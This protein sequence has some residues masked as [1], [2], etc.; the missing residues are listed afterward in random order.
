MTETTQGMVAVESEDVERIYTGEEVE[1]T[2]HEPGD[3]RGDVERSDVFVKCVGGLPDRDTDVEV[4]FG[5][6]IGITTAGVALMTMTN[7]PYA[8]ELL[9]AGVVTVV[10]ATVVPRITGGN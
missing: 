7:S 1:A 10:I 2:L 9:L 8:A 5:M 6:G 4:A 3:G